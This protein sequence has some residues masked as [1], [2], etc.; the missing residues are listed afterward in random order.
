MEDLILSRIDYGML[1][2]FMVI[3]I[4][5]VILVLGTPPPSEQKEEVSRAVVKV[6]Q[7]ALRHLPEYAF[8]AALLGF[9]IVLTIVSQQSDHTR[10]IESDTSQV[11]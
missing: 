7:V 8:L 4:F 3:L 6:E 1:A 9:F 10:T 5:V 2:L 11:R